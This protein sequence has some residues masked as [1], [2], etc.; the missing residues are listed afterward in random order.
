MRP[1]SRLA[2]LDKLTRSRRNT[3]LGR[4]RI[5]VHLSLILIALAFFGQSSLASLV[6][7]SV[8]ADFEV[9]TSAL[10]VLV[11]SRQLNG[12]DL[13]DAFICNVTMVS[14]TM[15]VSAAHCI[16]EDES[17]ELAV[18]L[19]SDLC[20]DPSGAEGIAVKSVRT[21]NGFSK[22]SL[23][24][25]V[26]YL[27]LVGAL[28]VPFEP[29]GDVLVGFGA[30]FRGAAVGCT[31]KLS[32]LAAV[33]LEVCRSAGARFDYH[34]GDND[35]CYVVSAGDGV[36]NGQS[37]AGLDRLDGPYI[38]SWSTGCGLHDAVRATLA[39]EPLTQHARS[40]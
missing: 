11:Q 29:H 20:V 40:G 15:A 10:P 26:A 28:S 35:R 27:E 23:T 25:D 18:V 7:G 38:I 17:I 22:V 6:Q 34:V 1:D 4:T 2:S 36:C 33:E 19:A 12:P 14:D 31:P 3:N 5:I 9:G 37:G 39:E 16:P 24:N 21:S 8:A 32:Q 30:P 13:R